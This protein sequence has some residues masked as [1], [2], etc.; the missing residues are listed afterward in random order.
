MQ[1]PA[2]HPVWKLLRMIVVGTFTTIALTLFLAYGYENHWSPNDWKTVVG[3]V[4]TT[5]ISIG[6]FDK[7][8]SLLTAPDGH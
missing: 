6:A 7:I 4:G 1:Y 5:L 2:D 3:A 8:K